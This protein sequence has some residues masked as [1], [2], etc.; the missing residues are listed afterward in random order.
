MNDTIDPKKV[1]LTMALIA[2]AVG[3]Y[4]A[5]ISRGFYNATMDEYFAGVTKGGT[6]FGASKR[7]FG[8]A[9]RLFY[10]AYWASATTVVG[11]ALVSVSY[12]LYQGKKWA[13]PLTVTILS[14]VPLGAGLF[15]WLGPV[16]NLQ[17]WPNTI[18]LTW[19]IGLGA[20]YAIVWL[21]PNDKKT[22][23][24]IIT[25]LTFMGMIGAQCGIFAIHWF[26]Q[27]LHSPD[28]M[29]LAI[30]DPSMKIIFTS[31]PVL[32]FVMILVYASMPA[33]AMRKD[34]GWL[35][36]MV[37]GWATVISAFPV[38]RLRNRASL[39]PEGFAQPSFLTDTFA[40]VG[41]LAVIMIVLLLIKNIREPLN[42]PDF[43]GKQLEG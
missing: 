11:I 8:T 20:F 34:Y 35:M 41:T 30:T 22:K 2:L 21:K 27:T 39:V 14:F 9:I 13:W 17:M 6:T 7:H 28:A 29:M 3:I 4:L 26:L 23:I 37:A 1:R 38:Y 12:W 32:T 5:L 40:E 25:I 31:S 15:S 24:A 36:A 16:A 18:L 19:L 10:G 42:G 33:I 43:S